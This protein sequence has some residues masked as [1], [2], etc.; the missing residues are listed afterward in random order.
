MDGK[1]KKTIYIIIAVVIILLITLFY[2]KIFLKNNY[3]EKNTWFSNLKNEG[4]E[5][6]SLD[7]KISF[8]YPQEIRLDKKNDRTTFWIIGN[9]GGDIGEISM[10]GFDFIENRK[11]DINE[12]YKENIFYKN[13]PKYF[14]GKNDILISGRPATLYQFND[15]DLDNCTDKDMIHEI[16]IKYN[17]TIYSFEFGSSA[18]ELQQRILNSVK[19]N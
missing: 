2:A 12:L 7:K 11:G 3:Y 10:F 6:V 1:S 5:F 4:G 15:C 18:T 14:Y 16:F 17:D 19:F 8:E 13:N 9:A